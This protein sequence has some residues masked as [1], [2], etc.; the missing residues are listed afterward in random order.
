MKQY[1]YR[2][3]TIEKTYLA[4]YANAILQSDK[5]IIIN[6]LT[7]EQV[8][9]YSHRETLKRLLTEL[10]K[11]VEEDRL[12]QILEDWGGEKVVECMLQKGLIE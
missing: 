5:L 10:E 12:C 3:D 9:V 6:T 2:S 7:D 8:Q 4:S 11:G 1:I